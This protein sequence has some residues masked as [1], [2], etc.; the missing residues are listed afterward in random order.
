MDLSI[1]PKHTKIIRDSKGDVLF[2]FPEN[3]LLDNILSDLWGKI[4][5]YKLVPFALGIS[6]KHYPGYRAVTL[7]EFDNK[8]NDIIKYYYDQKGFPNIFNLDF[9]CYTSI[10]IGGYWMLMQSEPIQCK[11]GNDKSKIISDRLSLLLFSNKLTDLCISINRCD[12]RN[13]CFTF[14]INDML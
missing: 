4:F 6:Y 10:V 9:T 3:T 7:T 5:W 13:Y 1:I 14:F 11:Y 2:E 8:K 12:S